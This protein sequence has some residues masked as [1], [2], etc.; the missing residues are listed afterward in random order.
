MAEGTEEVVDD[1]VDD[2]DVP[3]V[4]RVT[5]FSLDLDKEQ[6]KFLK[7]FALSNDIKASLVVRALL[8]LLETDINLANRVIDEILLD[9]EN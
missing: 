5:R 9:E 6:H 3:A 7:L 8:Y 1:V 4:R 2:F